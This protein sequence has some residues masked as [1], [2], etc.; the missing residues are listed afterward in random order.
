MSRLAPGEPLKSYF[1]ESVERM[2]IEEKISAMDKLGLNEPIYLQYFSWISKAIKGNFGISFKYKKNVIDVIGDM[3][4]NTIILSGISYI[5]TFASALILG[6]F[7][8]MNE[9]KFIDKLL[10]KVG[11]IT[12]CIPSFWLSLILILVFSI[13]LKILPSSGAYAIGQADNI[14]SRLV[15]LIMPVTVLVLSHLWYYT[16][17][18][19]NKLMEETRKDYVVLAK[20]KGLNKRK[21]IYKHCLKN[22]LPS[23]I[24]MMAISVPHLIGGTYIVE[25]VFSYPGLGTLCFE[26]AK[27]HDY[28]MLL[29]LSLITGIAVLLSNIIAQIINNKID[30]HIKDGGDIYL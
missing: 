4:I 1:G 14:G 20:M 3:Y 18:V 27:H 29:V 10:C 5:I 2:S 16:Y 22:I 24:S 30:N 28:N 11:A 26:S 17:I 7:C 23:Y 25:K 9:D 6:I 19:R 8:T 13:N 21:I 15:H 12:N